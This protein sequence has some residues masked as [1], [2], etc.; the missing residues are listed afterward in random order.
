MSDKSIILKPNTPP[1][2]L[3]DWNLLETQ[4]AATI[5]YN[6]VQAQVAEFLRKVTVGKPPEPE[7]KAQE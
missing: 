2:F 5:F 1:E 7:T 6:Q 4:Q 3:G